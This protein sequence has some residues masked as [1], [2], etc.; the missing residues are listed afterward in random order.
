MSASPEPLR[1]RK[2]ADWW[3]QFWQRP[4]AAT[5]RLLTCR[6]TAEE[7]LRLLGPTLARLPAGR[8]LRVLDLGCGHGDLTPLLLNESRLE[9]VAV[10]L[11]AAALGQFRARQAGRLPDRLRLTRASVYELPFADAAFDVVVSFGYASAASYAGAESEVA[12]VLRPGGLAIID[13][14][15]PSLY[16][17]V[18]APRATARWLQRYRDPSQE[19]YHFGRL[20]LR[21]HFAPARLHLEAVSYLNAYPPLERLAGQPWCGLLDRALSRLAGPLL[22]RVLLARLRRR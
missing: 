5:G 4:L 16:R 9:I 14:V 12:R 22:G 2:S 18:A 7:T 21:E 13:F 3:D 6:R 1:E 15:S 11:S 10:D 20:G 17:W 8:R 19:Q